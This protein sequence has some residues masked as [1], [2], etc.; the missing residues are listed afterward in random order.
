[1]KTKAVLFT[2]LF[3]VFSVILLSSCGEK[4]SLPSQP[5]KLDFLTAKGTALVDESGREVFLKGCNLG[6]WLNLEMWMM[7]VKDETVPDQY[8]FE[9]ILEDRF[10]R[11]ERDRLM[12]L[13]RANWITE[14]DFKIIKSF[15]FNCVRVPFHYNIIEN[16]A[17]PMTL[18]KD[19]F[20]WLDKAIGLAEKYDMYVI[21]DLH[22]VAGC[23]NLFDH[24]GR[25]EWNKF[26]A[27]K[28]Y[29]QRTAW[30]WE[31]I[32]S[33]YKDNATVAVYQPINEPWGGTMEE[34]V[35]AF[36]Y[37]YQ[38]IRKHDT[39]HVISSSGH[40]TGFDHYGDPKDHGWKGVA[41][42][43]NFY[44]GLFGGGPAIPEGHRG[45][46]VSLDENI[47]PKIDKLNIPFMVT[48]FNVVFKKAGGGK[49]MRR[50]YDE[51]EKHG[52]AAT[53]WSY[54]VLTSPGMSNTGGWW[55][56]TNAGDEV[57]GAWWAVTNKNKKPEIDFNRA[58]KKQIES[59]FKLLGTMDYLVNEDFRSAMIAK[60]KPAPLVPTG[61]LPPLDKAPANDKF[62]NWTATDIG[63]PWKG[64][65]QVIGDDALDIYAGGRD[66]YGTADQF[67]YVWQ[68]IKGDFELSLQVDSLDFTEV[69]AK[70]GIM[71][72]KSLGA[73][74]AC[75]TIDTIADGSIELGWRLSDAGQMETKT[76]MGTDF[77]VRL[78]IVRRDKV[79][80]RYFASEDE[81]WTKY[82]SIE[83][84]ALEP[85]AYVGMFC[86]SHNAGR[87]AK[88]ELRN[89]RLVQ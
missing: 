86:V 51:Y 66:V 74:S 68:K 71:V 52:W 45:F 2:T 16:E 27:D 25:K 49:M 38:A 19:A 83:F 42:S 8:T 69:Y 65:Q 56:V 47:Q 30:L 29:W 54:K 12:D 67:R 13:Y 55:F 84:P 76:I 28:V 41:Y 80:E 43:Q 77:P 17:E 57:T 50:H 5:Q 59:Y 34:Q 11:S 73:D 18:R 82:E 9:K 53:M 3:V 21:L 62:G 75:V 58:G 85:E 81:T 60:E 78:K 63:D 48:E 37:L 22:S 35:E 89:I 70:S 40:Y 26:W 14:R 46:F 1:M 33:R 6:S 36:D 7:D 23:Q 20:K 39:K 24:S 15:G 4:F 72:R 61:L 64:G 87:L 44:P 79:I 88:T 32:A 10:G 31:Q